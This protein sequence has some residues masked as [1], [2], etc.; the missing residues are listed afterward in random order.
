MVER[1]RIAELFD[2][3]GDD[4]FRLALSYLG[5]RADAEDVCQNVFLRLADGEM[6]LLPGKEK[7]WLMTCTAN[8]CKNHLKSFWRRNV[9]E[10]EESIPFRTQEERGLY[11]AVMA[12][13]AKYRA[14]IHLYYFEGYDQGEIG[15]ILRI[16]RTAVQT[17]MSR[18]RAMLKKELSDDERA[19]SEHDG[20]GDPV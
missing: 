2:R 18:A 5:N 17:R 16:S 20:A 7:A 11:E 8:A 9:G 10:L 15:D 3:Y 19:L 14:V 4:V 1:E 6:T 13:P 12:L